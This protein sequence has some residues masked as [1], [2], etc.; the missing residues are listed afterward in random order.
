MTNTVKVY[1]K[2]FGDSPFIACMDLDMAYREI[3]DPLFVW[4]G[5]TGGVIKG[6]KKAKL[7]DTGKLML[8]SFLKSMSG[9]YNCAVSYVIIV[10][11]Q[12]VIEYKTF[13]FLLMG[14]IFTAYQEPDYTYK[15]NL[16]FTTASCTFP[17]NFRA[18]ENLISMI[19]ESI[20]NVT[21]KVLEHSHECHVVKAPKLHLQTHLFITFKVIPSGS[22]RDEECPTNIDCAEE[23]NRHLQKKEGFVNVPKINYVEN[24]LDI[25]RIDSCRP[26][27]GKNEALHKD[28]PDCCVSCTTRKTVYVLIPVIL[29]II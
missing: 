1:V 15:V 12:K 14:L 17:I 19:A 21:C 10:N 13:S 3:L 6:C 9:T 24:S 16:R 27:Y 8:K 23:A 7:T 28:C 4:L 25:G 5:P 20:K 29:N 26:G 2:L 18:V 22:Q 11:D